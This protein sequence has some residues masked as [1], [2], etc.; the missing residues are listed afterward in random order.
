MGES[1]E[2]A[3]P[4]EWIGDWSGVGAAG[5]VVAVSA[6]FAFVLLFICLIVAKP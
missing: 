3:Q 2:R 6:G 5:V 4:V 1:L